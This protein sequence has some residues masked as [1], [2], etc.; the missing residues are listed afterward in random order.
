LLLL[1]LVLCLGVF[2]IAAQAQEPVGTPTG[3]E[4]VI[5]APE[6]VDVEPTARDEEIRA[7]LQGILEATGWFA[8]LEVLVEEGVVFFQGEAETE[9][10]KKWAGDLARRTQDVTAV[11]NQLEIVE[12]S[13]WDFQQVRSGLRQLGRTVLGAVPLI[14]FGLFVLFLSW[15]AARLTAVVARRALQ[16]RD[17]NPLLTNVVAWAVGL[18]ILLIGLYVVFQVTGL[19]SA[20]LTV[21]GGTGLLGLILGIA[22]RD[23]TE[24]FL[25]SVFLSV[26]TPFE[27]GDLVEIDGIMGFVQKLTTRA[28]ILM[29]QDG[30]HVLIP[31]ATVYKS[32][33]YNYSS[34]PNRRQDFVVGIAYQ[35]SVPAAQEIALKV[36]QDHP[37]VLD[38]PEPWILVEDLGAS[39]VNLRIYFWLD[40][41]QFSWQK[42]RSSVIRLVKSAFGAAGIEMPGETRELILPDRIPVELFRSDGAW[43]ETVPPHR[44]PAAPAGDEPDTVSMDAEGGLRSEAQEIQEQARRSRMPEEGED[45]LQPPSD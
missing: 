20:A 32:N 8:N 11:V 43:Q 3:E 36:L 28:T 31:N 10:Y 25:A 41:S 4:E 14:V 12:P 29:T 22:F 34:N 40:G 5:E 24:N 6:S 19:T 15:M 35:E 42:V 39:T 26:Q 21:V 18:L 27:S 13:V 23:I 1:I 16:R 44:H 17:W 9:E 38:E 7:R 33:I 2:T 37:A 45:L 30:N